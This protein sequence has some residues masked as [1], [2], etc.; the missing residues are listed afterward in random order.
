MWYETHASRC[1][2]RLSMFFAQTGVDCATLRSIRRRRQR[3]NSNT[4]TVQQEGDDVEEDMEEKLHFDFTQHSSKCDGERQ[5]KDMEG[6]M[7]SNLLGVTNKQEAA[8]PPRFAQCET[9]TSSLKSRFCCSASFCAILLHRFDVRAAPRGCD[10]RLLCA[11][12]FF[13]ASAMGVLSQCDPRPA[14]GRRSRH[15]F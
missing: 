14:L 9:D 2:S 5:Q 1:S 11:L 15:M 6:R 7:L 4:D 3:P 10:S 13:F 8:T 12:F